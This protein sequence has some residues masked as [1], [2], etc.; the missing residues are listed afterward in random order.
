MLAERQ[1]LD[2]TRLRD[3]GTTTLV[4]ELDGTEASAL[5]PASL[6][7]TPDAPTLTVGDVVLTLTEVESEAELE[8]LRFECLQGAGTS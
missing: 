6:D 5:F 1:V 4:F 8:T 7:G 2:V 3:G